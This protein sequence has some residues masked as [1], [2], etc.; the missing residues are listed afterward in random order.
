MR[1]HVQNTQ[2]SLPTYNCGAVVFLFH[3]PAYASFWISQAQK[4]GAL[5]IHKLELWG[6]ICFPAHVIFINSELLFSHTPPAQN[7]SALQ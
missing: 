6:L 1:D 5:K 2:D 3:Q 4:N 7:I